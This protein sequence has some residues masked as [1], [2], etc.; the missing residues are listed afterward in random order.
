MPG[1]SECASVANRQ[2]VGRF[3]NEFCA[4]ATNGK[5]HFK[6]VLLNRFRHCNDLIRMIGPEGLDLIKCPK[7]VHRGRSR[8]SKHRIGGLKITP[9]AGRKGHSVGRRNPDCWRAANHHVPDP[10]CY[11]FGSGVTNPLDSGRKDSL[12]Q[13]FQR[14]VGPAKGSKHLTILALAAEVPSGH[15]AGSRLGR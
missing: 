5:I 3:G 15:G 1:G 6:I 11:A 13:H 9:A 4:V 14:T 7:Q 10:L 2:D 12:V 8:C